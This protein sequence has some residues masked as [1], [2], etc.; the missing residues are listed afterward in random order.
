MQFQDSMGRKGSINFFFFF[1]P[2]GKIKIISKFQAELAQLEILQIQYCKTL[3]LS[4]CSILFKTSV[5]L[6]CPPEALRSTAHHAVLALLWH[7]GTWTTGVV[8]RSADA[9]GR[10][11]LIT[12]IS[13]LFLCSGP[14]GCFLIWFKSL[15]TEQQGVLWDLARGMSG[16]Y[17]TKWQV[18][19]RNSRMCVCSFRQNAQSFANPKQRPNFPNF[20]SAYHYLF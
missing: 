2:M 14:H 7:P 3:F 19:G 18:T 8:P 10:P 12:D 17:H 4:E 1:F 15:S 11:G 6:E 5:E 13:G 16:C 20:I 9:C